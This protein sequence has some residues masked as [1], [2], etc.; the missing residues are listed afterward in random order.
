MR[1][2]VCNKDAISYT[3]LY[4]ITTV[5]DGFVIKTSSPE[6]ESKLIE[7]QSNGSIQCTVSTDS[8]ILKAYNSARG[9][10]YVSKF[11]VGNIDSL[12]N[13]FQKDTIFQKSA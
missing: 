7:A 3:I 11:N 10:I 4:Y 9:I 6:Q 2:H 1:L 5:R 13:G 12:T 8:P